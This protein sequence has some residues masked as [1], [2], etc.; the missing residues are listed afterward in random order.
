MPYVEG[1]SL[2]D[3]LRRE[4]QLPLVEAVRLAGEVAEALS[5]AHQHGIVHRDVKPENILLSRGHARVSDFGVARALEVASEVKLTET[6]LALGTPAYMSP[7]QAFGGPLDGR[8]D[9]YA[10]GCVLFEMLA[11]QPPFVAAT[12][13]SVL[14]RHAVDPPPSIAQRSGTSWHV[15]LIGRSPRSQ[16]TALEPR[17]ILLSPYTGL[18]ILPPL[19]T[20]PART[21]SESA[22]NPSPSSHSQTSDSLRM[23]TSQTE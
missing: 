22:K 3:R 15:L 18:S 23:S 10:L 11:G 14:A 2:R 6:G 9:L 16:R 13:R 20:T 5:C 4:V 12:A 19:P 21:T 8:S 1:G 17:M 7:E